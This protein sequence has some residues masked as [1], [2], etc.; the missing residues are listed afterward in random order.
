M[1]VH[2]LRKA[3]MRS[4]VGSY[5]ERVLRRAFKEVTRVKKAA[6]T[7]NGRDSTGIL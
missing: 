6:I 5:H 1:T 7:A 3:D 4:G 2:R